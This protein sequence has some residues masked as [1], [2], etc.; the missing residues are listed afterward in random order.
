MG[1]RLEREGHWGPLLSQEGGASGTSWGCGVG[2]MGA[3]M[4]FEF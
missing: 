2:G 1:R 3:F 4:S